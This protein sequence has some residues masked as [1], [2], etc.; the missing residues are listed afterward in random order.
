MSQE[1]Y[2]SEIRSTVVNN[3]I[4]IFMLNKEKNPCYNPQHDDMDFIKDDYYMQ[5]GIVDL[6]AFFNEELLCKTVTEMVVHSKVAMKACIIFFVG[7]NEI[8][9]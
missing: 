9:D 4:C 8:D 5:A 6:T 7:F 2:K 3:Y 1:R